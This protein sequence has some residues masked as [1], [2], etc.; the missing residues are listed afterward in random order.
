[1]GILQLKKVKYK[2]NNCG[3][4]ATDYDTGIMR[5]FQAIVAYTHWGDKC[6][7]ARL[8]MLPTYQKSIK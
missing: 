5:D 2:Q 6:I 4:Y 7:K 3:Q 1:M 8:K